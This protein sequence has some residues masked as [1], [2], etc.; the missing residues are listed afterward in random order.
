MGV[1]D[2]PA[3]SGSNFKQP[4]QTAAERIAGHR[5]GGWKTA[6]KVDK[7][8]D[9]TQAGR[10]ASARQREIEVKRETRVIVWLRS[11]VCEICAMSEQ[12]TAAVYWKSQHEQDEWKPRSL[13]RNEPPEIRF[14]PSNT[15]RDCALCHRY[16]TDHLIEVI[17]ADDVLQMSGDYA[18][19]DADG[20]LLRKVSRA[21]PQIEQR[22]IRWMRDADG[23]CSLVKIAEVA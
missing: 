15:I 8:G 9:E 11:D 6:P 13:T 7:H 14:A 17:P 22:T 19:Y 16:R 20:H 4:R 3:F 2:I 1:Y 5:K 18:I 23:V 21:L 10:K 12:E